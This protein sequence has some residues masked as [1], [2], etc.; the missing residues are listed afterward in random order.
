MRDVLDVKCQMT[1]NIVL[2]RSGSEDSSAD[3]CFCTL[4]CILCVLVTLS[5]RLRPSFVHLWGYQIKVCSPQKTKVYSSHCYITFQGLCHKSDLNSFTDFSFNF[6]KQSQTVVVIRRLTNETTGPVLLMPSSLL[7]A[8]NL[9][10][11]NF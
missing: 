1:A 2:S 9:N 6:L 3:C 11:S 5:P 7:S 8:G 10:Y 4:P